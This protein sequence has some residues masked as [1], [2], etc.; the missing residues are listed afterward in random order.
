MLTRL[1]LLVLSVGAAA[2]SPGPLLT[3]PIAARSP[4]SVSTVVLLENPLAKFFGGN[5]NQEKE[6]TSSSL[7]KTIDQALVGAPLPAKIL[8]NV[9]I[10]PLAGALEN[11]LRESAEDSDD[12]INQA[13]SALRRDPDVLAALGV[14][15]DVLEAGPIF[16]SLGGSSNINGQISKNL[17][18]Q[19]QVVGGAIA[20]ARGQGDESGRMKLVDVQLRVGTR[21]MTVA[22]VGGASAGGRGGSSGGVIDVEATTIDV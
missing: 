15:A 16:S 12:L 8:A 10:K 18:L 17:Q 3:S 5:K 20:V 1:L 7:A 4:R 2:F 19:F 6:K 11:T 13:V 9:L 14:S 22:G 21:V